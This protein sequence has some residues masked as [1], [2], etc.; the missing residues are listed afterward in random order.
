F[1]FTDIEGSTQ[2]LHRL[3]DRYAGVLGE[4]RKILRTAFEKWDGYEVDTQGDAFFVA[5][6]RATDAVTASVEAQRA[7]SEFPW[8]EGETVRVR[9]GLH[10]GQPQATS[11]GY[12]GVDVHRAA[13][14]AHAGHGGQVLLSETVFALVR[15]A[16]PEDVS[17]RN[18]GEHQLKDLQRPDSIYQLVIKGMQTEF[19]PI[20]SLDAHQHNLPIQLTPLIG[21]E[22]EL[23]TTQELLTQPEVR[24]LTLTGPGGI[25]KTRLAL[26]LAA[27]IS[28]E[29]PD[30]IYFVPLAPVLEPELVTPTIAQTLGIRDDGIEPLIQVLIENIGS[31]RLLLLLDNFEQVIPSATIIAELLTNCACLTIIIASREILHLRGEQEFNVPPLRSPDIS[32]LPVR[33]ILTENPAI[34]LF[35]Q[36][37]A[38]VEPSFELTDDN[39]GTVAEICACL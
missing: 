6:Q 39:V 34:E 18:L 23:A 1:L 3:G 8:T 4:Q 29:Y 38:A 11:T 10:T 24:L 19:P 9:M 5:F 36:R 25:G 32:Q 16:L 26:Q 30:G 28:H 17:L 7:L 27:E 21:R 20:K 13:R 37:A 35:T 2:L 14:I 12:V 31:K 15:D 22:D 33:T